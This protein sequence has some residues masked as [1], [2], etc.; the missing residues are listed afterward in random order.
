MGS[1]AERFGAED[2][3]GGVGGVAEGGF[4][5]GEGGAVAGVGE[6]GGFAGAGAEENLIMK[7]EAIPVET[8][9]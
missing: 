7:V 5:V 3:F 4:G 1:G 6:Q 2:G 9:A 8:A